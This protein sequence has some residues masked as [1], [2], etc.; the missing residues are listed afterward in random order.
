[1][2]RQIII[3]IPPTTDYTIVFPHDA[4]GKRFD[5]GFYAPGLTD[6]RASREEIDQ[7]LTEVENVRRPLNG[8]IVSAVCCYIFG[9]FAAVGGYVFL[10]VS[11]ASEVPDMIP[12]F[13]IGFIGLIIALIW[14]FIA[15]VKNVNVEMK[16]KCKAVVD[17]HNP[18]FASRGLR[19]HV[20]VHFP[21]WIELWKDY[22][23]GN[24]PQ[25]IYMPP[26]NQQPYSPNS[27]YGTNQNMGGQPQFQQQ[28]YY[29]NY[30]GPN[31]NNMYIPPSQV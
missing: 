20:P 19:W 17:R 25:P 31:N 29:Q 1:M 10:M 9:L 5:S 24:N 30:Q 6:G 12:F 15:R 28:N 4:V 21:R 14:I 18:N 8:K 7:V 23:A 13:V 26:V 27:N 3:A 16:T 11:M 2:T 22:R